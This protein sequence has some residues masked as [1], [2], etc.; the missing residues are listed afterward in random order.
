MAVQPARRA[1]APYPL[2]RSRERRIS[3]SNDP[4]PPGYVGAGGGE[5]ERARRRP[6]ARRRRRTA[7]AE[8]EGMVVMLLLTCTATSVL[9]PVMG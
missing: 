5:P 1:Y 7:V 9:C 4:F 6:R 2:E 8:P 3:F